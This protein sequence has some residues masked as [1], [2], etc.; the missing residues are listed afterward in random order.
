MKYHEVFYCQ[1]L[2]VVV[3]YQQ[4]IGQSLTLQSL[5]LN[6]ERS[7]LRMDIFVYDNSPE[8]Q[9]VEPEFPWKSFN[10]YYAHDPDNGGLSKA[11]NTAAVRARLLKKT[12]LLL[13]DQDTIFSV[14]FLEVYAHTVN[15]NPQ[16][17]IFAPLLQLERGKIFSPCLLRHKRG[18]PPRKIASGKHRLSVYSPVNSGL[19]VSLNLFLKVG[20]YNEKLKIDFCDFQFLEKVRKV[21][22]YFFLTTATGLQ[23]YS[24]AEKSVQKQ[25]HRFRMYLLDAINSD[26]P[27]LADEIGFFYAVTRHTLGLTIKLRSLS[28]LGLYFHYYLTHYLQATA[29]P[30]PTPQS[31]SRKDQLLQ[32]EETEHN[33]HSVCMA[34]FNGEKYIGAQIES[35]L[36]QLGPDDELI[37]SDDGSTD[38]T[39]EIIK[40]FSDSRIKL[41][42]DYIFRDPIK[43]FQ[44]A[45]R[46]SSGKYIFLSDQDDVWM[47]G[48]YTLML[49][50]LEKYDLVISDSLIVDQELK[51]LHPSFFDYFSSGRG[52]LKNMFKSSYYGSCMAFNRNVLEAALPF[53]DTKEIGHDLWIG[54]VAELRFSVFFFREPLIKY[55]RHEAVFTSKRVGKSKRNLIQMLNGRFIMTKE[56]IKF[57]VRSRS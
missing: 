19:L 15:E 33:Y 21:S 55:R 24:N 26:K 32:L 56:I 30:E 13:L 43:N 34:T 1:L 53:P 39:V 38:Q 40:T 45:L 6:L 37:I 16:L 57:L 44:H 29:A 49:Q 36:A 22:P 27:S 8:P 52:L 35:I 18:Y 9:A 17:E 42:Q 7:G 4:N 20:G 23:N 50:K 54:L 14:D 2:P 10:V 12:W 46:K 48:K 47:E 51:V 5:Q 41:F 31:A 3:L 28:F 25:Q 11:Y